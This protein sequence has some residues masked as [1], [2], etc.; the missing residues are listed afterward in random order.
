MKSHCVHGLAMYLLKITLDHTIFK[1]LPPNCTEQ[2]Y[3]PPLTLKVMVI[4][5]GMMNLMSQTRS[6]YKNINP[7]K[8]KHKRL[9]VII[10]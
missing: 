9:P 1:N 6:H 8:I 2:F 4:R 5:V 10:N 3:P 7:A